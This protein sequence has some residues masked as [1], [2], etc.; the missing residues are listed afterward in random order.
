MGH[1]DSCTNEPNNYNY[2]AYDCSTCKQFRKLKEQHKGKELKS[3]FY[4][5]IIKEPKPETKNTKVV[6]INNN[7]TINNIINYIETKDLIFYVTITSNV[8]DAAERLRYMFTYLMCGNSGKQLFPNEP[9]YSRAVTFPV[10]AA[11]YDIIT[12]GNT[13]ILQGLL[14]YKHQK[15]T[16]MT[17]KKLENLGDIY[18]VVKAYCPDICNNNRSHLVKTDIDKFLNPISHSEYGSSIE[19][20]YIQDIT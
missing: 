11:K 20:F 7:L 1:C 3:Y 14:R 4:E 9:K 17:I 19:D 10:T 13:C 18:Y 16:S 5:H 8:P 2:C 6:N 15:T 12:N